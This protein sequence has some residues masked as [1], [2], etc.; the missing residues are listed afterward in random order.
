MVKLSTKSIR[1]YLLEFS[2]IFLG[3]T[4]SFALSEISERQTLKKNESKIIADLTSEVSL[5]KAY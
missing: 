3:V 5:I 2:A 4:A 1:K